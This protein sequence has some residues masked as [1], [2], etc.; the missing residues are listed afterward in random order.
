MTDD[1]YEG[2]SNRETWALVR[3]L[4]NNE[5]YH[6][7]RCEMVKSALIGAGFTKDDYDRQ[8]TVD[9]VT[10]QLEKWV[11]SLVLDGIEVSGPRIA[12]MDARSL[13]SDVG[14]PWRVDFAEIADRWVHDAEDEMVRAMS[15]G[16]P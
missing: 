7:W 13:V 16:R 1:T 14:S 8:A 11:F 6:T 3:N 2:W 10:D 15:V 4:D 9:D 5:A 12:P